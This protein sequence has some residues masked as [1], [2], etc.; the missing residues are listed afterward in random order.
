[1]Y[2]TPHV[3]SGLERD[4]PLL[5]VNNSSMIEVW[6]IHVKINAV[7]SPHKNTSGKKNKDGYVDLIECFNAFKVINIQKPPD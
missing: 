2:G 4:V 1:M 5:R 7:L 6:N 3:S